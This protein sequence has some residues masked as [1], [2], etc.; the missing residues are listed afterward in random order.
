M[1]RG[2]GARDTFFD[3]PFPGFG[4]FGD[5]GGHRSLLSNFMG[6]RDPFND[7][8][9]THPFGS[10]FEPSFFS[11]SGSPFTGMPVSGFL[12]NQVPRSNHSRGPIIEELHSDDEREEEGN[13]EKKQNPKKH[14]RS[15]EEHYVEDPDDV[16][17]ERRNKHMQYRNAFNRV[18]GTQAQ[19]QV[20]SFTFQSSTVTYGGGNGAYYSS[21]RTRRTGSDGLTVEESRKA[22]TSTGQ[23]THRISRGIHD[24]GHSVTRKL[25]SGG[26]VDTMQ[27][28]HNLN[29]D[30]LT[31]FEDAWKGN[32]RKHLPG[33]SERFG[34]LHNM[35][36]SSSIQN[37]QAGRGGWAL[38]STESLPCSGR[39]HA[40]VGGT[41]G[42]HPTGRRTADFGGRTGPAQTSWEDSGRMKADNGHWPGC[43]RG[44]D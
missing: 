1:Q 12:E 23:A 16:A 40:G 17:E 24:K 21:S 43:S 41:T 5:F 18:N 11:S 20:Q 35:G 7:P 30:E 32:A 2:R 33:W 36:S 29:E 14:P 34:T 9:F 42:L 8:F 39:M 38:P 13:K 28:L 10:M 44:R 37:G 19:P 3:F 31:A 22:D 25:D 6:G 27:T 4:G 26:K 15:S